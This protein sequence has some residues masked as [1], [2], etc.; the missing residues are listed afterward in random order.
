MACKTPMIHVLNQPIK[1][2]DT[3]R[4]INATVYKETPQMHT[5]A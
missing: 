3:N 2:Q 1:S 4:I 5:H